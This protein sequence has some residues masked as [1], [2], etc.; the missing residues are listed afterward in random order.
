MGHY[1]ARRLLQLIPVLIGTMFLLHLLTSFSI[2]LNGDPARAVFGERRPLPGQLE[3][4][5]ERMGIDDPCLRQPGNPCLKLFGE[6]MVNIAQGDFGANFRGEEVTTLVARAVPFSIKLTA[7]AFIVIIGIGL[8]AGVL[9]GLRNGSFIDYVVKVSTVVLVSVP[10]FVLGRVTQL[11]GGVGLGGWAKD[12]D[13]VPQV[14]T[15]ILVI[16]YVPSK[17]WTSLV[18][19]GVILGS[20]SLAYVARLTRTSL[21]EN[22]RGD[23]V[24]TATAKGLKRSRVIGV[25]TLRNSLIPVVTYLGIT[26]GDLM[27]GAIVTEGIFNVPGVGRLTFSSISRGEAPVVIGVVTMIVLIYLFA[28]LIVDLLYA[29]LDPR[30]RYE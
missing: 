9:A 16:S 25:H 2:Q 18:I 5:Q 29:V 11:Y 7:I 23:Y 28:S 6:R 19:P 30:I 24:R 1:V 8:V 10:I 20:L 17:P 15:D 14:L 26:I 13:W 4:M 21:M 22:L 27:A 3:R 12:Q